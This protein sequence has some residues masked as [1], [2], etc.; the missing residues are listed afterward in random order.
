MTFQSDIHETSDGR[1][2]FDFLFGEWD[3]VARKTKDVLD[4]TCE[5]WDEFVMR[6]V[7]RPLLGGMGNTDSCETASGPDGQPFLGLSVRLFDPR[8]RLWRIWWASNRNPGHLDPPVTGRFDG[9][10]GVFQGPDLVGGREVEV[11]FTWRVTGPATA[12]WRQAFSLDG[13][14]SWHVNFTMD[15]SRC[16]A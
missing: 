8:D 10:I 3:V 6:Q 9:G 16:E 2:D 14:S 4:P 11:R 7:A 1:A 15:F 12:E 5:E 13:G